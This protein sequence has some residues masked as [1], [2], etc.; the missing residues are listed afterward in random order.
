MWKTEFVC[1]DLI[2][3]GQ[4]HGNYNIATTIKIGGKRIDIPDISDILSGELK[5]TNKDGVINY[6]DGG[7]IV[8]LNRFKNEPYNFTTSRNIIFS[9]KDPDLDNPNDGNLDIVK[10]IASKTLFIP[11]TLQMKK[12]VMR[13]T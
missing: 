13:H 1:V 6:D 10:Y 5:D 12:P 9:L 8:E 3:N 2:L 11:I 7:F 4:Y